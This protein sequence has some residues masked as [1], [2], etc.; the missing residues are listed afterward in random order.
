MV[1]I[2]GLRH[3]ARSSTTMTR[4]SMSASAG[5]SGRHTSHTLRGM[6]FTV[7]NPSQAASR[8]GV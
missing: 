5:P 2:C 1:C 6:A 7:W 8:Q 3:H 4:S